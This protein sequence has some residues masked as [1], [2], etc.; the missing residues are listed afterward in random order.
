MRYISI[1]LREG[2]SFGHF[3]YTW[4]H[5]NTNLAIGGFLASLHRSPLIFQFAFSGFTNSLKINNARDFQPTDF[6]RSIKTYLM[7]YAKCLKKNH[8]SMLVMNL[9]LPT[10]ILFPKP[11]KGCNQPLEKMHTICLMQKQVVGSLI[12]GP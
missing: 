8:H 10:Q 4:N 5:K 1:H 2:N 11:S 6:R 3:H 9:T 12:M 7:A